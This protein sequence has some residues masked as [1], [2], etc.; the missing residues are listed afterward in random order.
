MFADKCR[1][2]ISLPTRRALVAL[3]CAA[4]LA[5][6]AAASD[7]TSPPRIM[8]EYDEAASAVRVAASIDIPTTPQTVYAVMVDCSRA[9]RIVTGLESCRVIEKGVDGSWDIRE[10]IIAT[11]VFLPRFRNV[12]RSDYHRN[13]LI[14][15]RRV[16]GDLRVSEG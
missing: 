11:S 14:R 10:H 16:D 6:R 12:F 2:T 7:D 1:P 13:R 8:V 3:M 4:A 9:L 15:F 5:P